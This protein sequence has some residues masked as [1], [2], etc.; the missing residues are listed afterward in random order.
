[1][2]HDLSCD[3]LII[4]NLP[5]RAISRVH[6]FCHPA[7]AVDAVDGKALE[8]AAFDELFDDF[9]HVKALI[10]KVISGGSGEQQQREPMLTV[11]DDLH[12]LVEAG[13][14]PT[15]YEALHH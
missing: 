1:M 8:F 7:F 3:V 9:D 11:N 4:L 12:M 6:P 10:L 2:R 14:V 15:I 13:A 5:N